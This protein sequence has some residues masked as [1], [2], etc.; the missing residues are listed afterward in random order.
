MDSLA[1]EASY[2]LSA[3]YGDDVFASI[4]HEDSSH[5]KYHGYANDVWN[6][7]VRVD[8]GLAKECPRW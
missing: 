1:G 5:R 8:G 6:D 4:P 2:D 3:G 7:F